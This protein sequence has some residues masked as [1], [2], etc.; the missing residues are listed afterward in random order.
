MFNDSNALITLM[1]R[2]FPQFQSAID[3]YSGAGGNY[4]SR[5]SYPA[6]NFGSLLDNA[7]PSYEG[8]FDLPASPFSSS[9]D[10]FG[11]PSPQRYDQSSISA[12][13]DYSTAPLGSPLFAHPQTALPRMTTMDPAFHQAAARQANARAAQNYNDWQDFDGDVDD[14]PLPTVSSTSFNIADAIFT[15]LGLINPAFGLLSLPF[16]M[17]RGYNYFF[18]DDEVDEQ[19]MEDFGIDPTGQFTGIGGPAGADDT[20]VGANAPETEA[21]GE[22]FDPGEFSDD[23]APSGTTSVSGAAEGAES[24]GADD[25]SDDGAGGP[26]DSG[27]AEGGPFHLGGL[28]GGSGPKDITAEG[29]EYIIR[30]SAV[31][32]YGRGLFDDLNENK[33]GKRQ[34]KGLLDA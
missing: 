25:G 20:S 13:P 24:V 22:G 34:L 30:K 17:V 1:L 4:T 21:F 7:P 29:G 10:Q 27:D 8:T 16:T 33:I 9:Y 19:Y 2:E 18:G 11:I 14:A 26:S 31:K 15:A 6:G 5:G 32:K 28:L 12:A 3:S 23:G